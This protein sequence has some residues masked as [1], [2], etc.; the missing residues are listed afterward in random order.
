MIDVHSHI[1]PGI[2]DGAR[3]FEHS[4]EIVRI[5]ANQ[6][7]TEIIA[8][9]H[10]VNDSIYMSKKTDNVKLLKELQK[11]LDEESVDVKLYLGN[12]IYIERNIKE[13]LKK[14]QITTMADGAYLLVELPLNDEFPNYVDIFGELIGSGYK[15][16]L[17]HP[18]RYA[19]IQEDFEKLRELCEIGVLL[20][21]NLG[22]ILGKYD[23]HAK[24]TLIRLAKEKMVF[25]FG[26]D[27]HS[28]RHP[29]EVTM[30]IKKLHKYYNDEELEKLLV[31]NP[32]MMIE[33]EAPKMPSAKKT[34]NTAKKKTTTKGK[35]K[36]KSKTTKKS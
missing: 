28:T 30:G 2:D 23:K 11:R 27:I 7:V 1:L 29:E 17:A 24:K 14:R 36:A 18:E 35:G 4:V 20:Q 31:K 13:L 5:L 9:P 34:N 6:G 8:T 21:C 15:V 10:F 33:S 32:R 3:T 19:F 22:S 12:E 16:L 25:T 26:S